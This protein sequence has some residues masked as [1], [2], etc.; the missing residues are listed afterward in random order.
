MPLIAASIKDRIQDFA[1]L[2]MFATELSVSLYK[3]QKPIISRS[4]GKNAEKPLRHTGA[5]VQIDV[6]FSKPASF[7]GSKSLAEGIFGESPAP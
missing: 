7:K 1:N 2:E 4:W 3:L 5:N 6:Q